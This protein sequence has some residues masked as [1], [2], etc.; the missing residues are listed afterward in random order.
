MTAEMRSGKTKRGKDMRLM[1]ASAGSTVCMSR[2][3]PSAAYAPKVA[4]ETV[5][6]AEFQKMLCRL[7]M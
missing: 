2:V 1:I 4:I 7:E 6:G 3:F 5:T